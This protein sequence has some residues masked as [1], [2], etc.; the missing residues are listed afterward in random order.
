MRPEQTGNQILDA[1]LEEDKM[2]SEDICKSLVSIN[3]WLCICDH[4]FIT[5]SVQER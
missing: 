3:F 5:A 1:Q 2:S 4:A